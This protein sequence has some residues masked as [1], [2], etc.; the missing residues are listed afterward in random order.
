MTNPLENFVH[1]LYAEEQE[2]KIAAADLDHLSLEELSA[3]IGL[4]LD[5]EFEKKASLVA[6]VAYGDSE[7]Y[8]EDF[9]GT[10]LYAEAIALCEKMLQA[11][12]E[13]IKRRQE[14][15][16]ERASEDNIYDVKD[17]LRL[18][19][20]ML[21]LKLHKMRAAGAA[22]PSDDDDEGDDE[23]K[24]SAAEAAGIAGS[25]NVE[26]VG[27]VNTGVSE[28]PTWP[29]AAMGVD[30]AG[31]KATPSE[32]KK[33]DEPGGTPQHVEPK[34]AGL[35]DAIYQGEVDQASRLSHL[36]LHAAYVKQAEMTDA[37]QEKGLGKAV[38]GLAKSKA[39]PEQKKNLMKGV[40]KAVE[41]EHEEGDDVK[42][43]ALADYF[44]GPDISSMDPETLKKFKH[45]MA[46]VGAGAGALGAGAGA[47]LGA[48][49]G[50]RLVSGLAG[51]VGGGAGGYLGG[52]T[53]LAIR[54]MLDR[55]R[56]RTKGRGTLGGKL[57][58]PTG[59][60]L[61][62]MDE[63]LVGDDVYVS[64]EK[65]EEAKARGMKKK[66]SLSGTTKVAKP[67]WAKALKMMAQEARPGAARRIA[68][69]A[70][71]G[72]S[73]GAL[74]SATREG[75]KQ[76]AR[77]NKPSVRAALLGGVAGHGARSAPGKALKGA[78]AGGA[79]G[80]V[81]QAAAEALR[82]PTGRRLAEAAKRKAR[83]GKAVAQGRAMNA[84]ERLK[85]RVAASLSR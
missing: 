47:A 18:Q 61:Q 59:G 26:Y 14:R 75:V 58:H 17:Q 30:S 23:E 56:G 76:I 77:G 52:R 6:K 20:K 1:G 72:A 73:G 12:A 21:K 9:E 5:P 60:T 69:V 35:L 46:L 25:G 40:A 79:G 42:V 74:G 67:R 82:T 63:F 15:S 48:P 36:P 55:S 28:A 53:G 8:L 29:R 3:V 31:R 11:E 64:P 50:S 65:V 66:S 41:K 32:A 2:R 7:E 10:P 85:S 81:A 62:K 49:R 80:G 38:R 16:K 68:T 37:E 54:E 70:G 57:V 44:Q 45:R 33:R 71:A 24:T 83:L 34:T 43:S 51:A 4:D 84:A 22:P 39:D 27:D 13:C 78:V 19:K